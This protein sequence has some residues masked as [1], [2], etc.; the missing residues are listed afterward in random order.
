[1]ALHS[2]DPYLCKN[3]RCVGLITAD[4]TRVL[5]LGDRLVNLTQGDPIVLGAYNWLGYHSPGPLS[6]D[7]TIAVDNYELAVNEFNQASLGGLPGGTGGALRPVLMVVCRAI[8]SASEASIQHLLNTLEVP[9]I[10]AFLSPADLNRAFNLADGRALFVNPTESTSARA[11]TNQDY[12][13]WHL[14]GSP[15]DYAPP[16]AALLRRTEAY[17]RAQRAGTTDATKPLYVTLV[18]SDLPTLTL[19]VEAL[20]PLLRFNGMDAA[21]NEAAGYLRR[22]GT[23]SDLMH[24]VGDA[25]DALNELELHPPDIILGMATGE[26]VEQGIWQLEVDWS[27]KAPGRPRPFYLLAPTLFT[28]STLMGIGWQLENRTVGINAAHYSDP[29]LY[30]E[31]VSRFVQAYPLLTGSEFTQAEY[32]YDAAY[33][34]LYSVTASAQPGFTGASLA[35]GFLRIIDPQALPV[36]IGP[37]PLSSEIQPLRRFAYYRIQLTGT[38]GPPNFDLGSGVRTTTI[39]AW[40]LQQKGG[41]VEYEGDALRYNDASGEFDGVFPCF[42]GF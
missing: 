32:F 11:N 8:P 16:M 12:L 40:C 23:Q 36:D 34:L 13:L 9:G 18:D 7:N 24:D 20:R 22:V 38:T 17:L 4:C 1:V 2:G 3:Q 19:T 6:R 29:R 26:F 42:P 41:I 5:G 35:Q 28:S 37:M 15:E 14:L 31:Y 21:Q 27:T 39:G 33:Y 30:Q 25:W 10:V